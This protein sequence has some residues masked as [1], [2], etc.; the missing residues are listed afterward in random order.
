MYEEHGP[1]HRKTRLWNYFHS[2][3]AGKKKKETAIE[4]NVILKEI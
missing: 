3:I 2:E 1:I 4:L